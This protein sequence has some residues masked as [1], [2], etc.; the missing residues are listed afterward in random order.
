MKLALSIL[1]SSTLLLSACGPTDP[2]AKKQNR[3]ASN[4]ALFPDPADRTGVILA[5]PI[6]SFGFGSTIEFVYVPKEVSEAT[7]IKRMRKYCA[8]HK[9]DFITGNAFVR[10]RG[11]KDSTYTDP[12]TGIT[13]AV[14]QVYLTC[15]TP[16]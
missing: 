3:E 13:K 8:Q 12:D 16:S 4:A 6:E 1:L 10:K 7:L 5:F 14:R 15:V 2:K 9:S 11:T